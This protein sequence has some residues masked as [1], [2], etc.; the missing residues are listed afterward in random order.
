MTK[1]I[2]LPY[3]FDPS[4]I[5]RIRRF[6]SSLSN[7]YP[8]FDTWLT[9]KVIGSSD[10]IILLAMENESI[11]GVAIGRQGDEPKMRC[12]RTHPE[13]KGTGLGIKLMD[14]MIEHLQCEKPHVTVAEEMLHE[15]SR[16]FFKRYGF[17]L[18]DVVKG[19]FRPRK[20]EYHWN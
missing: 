13:L 6:L 17:Q 2:Q 16:L 15:Y 1:I 9:N 4:V 12:V 5:L 8:G 10:S 19:E 18:S 11:A 14:S 7:L 20:L 3:E